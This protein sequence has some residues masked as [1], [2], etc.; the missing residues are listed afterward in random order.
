MQRDEPQPKGFTPIQDAKA[1]AGIAMLVARSI[2]APLEPFLRSRFGSRYFG[3]PSL[4][5]LFTILF[6]CVLWPGEDP[7]PMVW[8]WWL[9]IAVQLLARLESIGPAARARP[10]HTRYNGRPRVASVFRKTPERTLKARHEPW[11]VI[12]IGLTVLGLSLPLGSYLIAAGFCLAVCAGVSEAAE[13]AV[14]L[15]LHDAWI[16]QQLLAERFRDMQ[17]G[18]R[19]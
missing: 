1:A 15:Q 3:L 13:R 17:R 19:Q 12:A 2:A 11:L 6:W 9:F 10:V 16:E 14:A 4:I 5:G 18:G 8:F 7:T